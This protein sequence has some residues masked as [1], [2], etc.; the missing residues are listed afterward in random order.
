MSQDLIAHSPHTVGA[1]GEFPTGIVTA[2]A[3]RAAGSEVNFTFPYAGGVKPLA[4]C[5]GAASM[6]NPAAADAATGRR[7]KRILLEAY[8]NIGNL[9]Y[10]H[11]GQPKAG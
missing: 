5:H 11:V 6:K 3:E 10:F 7:R 2:G 9:A 8:V 4:I 1:A